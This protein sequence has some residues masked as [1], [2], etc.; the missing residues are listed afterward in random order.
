MGDKAD[1]LALKDSCVILLDRHLDD[2]LF[3]VFA[4]Q[5][6]VSSNNITHPC[7]LEKLGRR[8]AEDHM[9]VVDAEHGRIVSKA[10][11]KAAVYEAVIVD[12]HRL[13]RL[14]F[15][16]GAS[17]GELDWRTAEGCIGR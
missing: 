3:T 1:E 15:D 5:P 2:F 17:L 9:R 12:D 8:C 14:K 16:E 13:G 6:G 11:D 4:A 7:R 10:E